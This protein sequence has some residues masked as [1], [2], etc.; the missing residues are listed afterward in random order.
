MIQNGKNRDLIE[1][2]LEEI[3][4]KPVRIK[5]ELGGKLKA[6]SSSKKKEEVDSATIFGSVE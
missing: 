6:N 2:T 1:Q 5:G 3:V 4:A